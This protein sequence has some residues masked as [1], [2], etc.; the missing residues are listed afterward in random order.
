MLYV[1]FEV[2]FEVPVNTQDETRTY[3]LEYLFGTGFPSND[4]GTKIS[5][6]NDFPYYASSTFSGVNVTLADNKTVNLTGQ[7]YSNSSS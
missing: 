7:S 3:Y 2:P 1:G 4:L 6:G 5:V